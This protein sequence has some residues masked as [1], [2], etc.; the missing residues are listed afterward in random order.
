MSC[1]LLSRWVRNSHADRTGA[2]MEQG[3][4]FDGFFKRPCEWHKQVG[5]RIGYERIRCD[6]V[7]PVLVLAIF[8]HD[9]VSPGEE[10]R[11]ADERQVNQNLPLDMFGVFIRDID[12]RF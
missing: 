3:A 8:L 11:R 9:L 7:T 4:G 5:Y 10:D 2:V 12:E 6:T 1:A